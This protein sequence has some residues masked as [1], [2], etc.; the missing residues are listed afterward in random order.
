MSALAQ[1]SHTPEQY[2]T[3]ERQASHKSEYVIRLVSIECEI[4]LREI[5]AKVEL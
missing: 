3:L 2:L 5:Y 4:S 1:S